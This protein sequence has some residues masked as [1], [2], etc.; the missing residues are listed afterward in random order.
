MCVY[1]LTKSEPEMRESGDGGGGAQQ[2]LHDTNIS[3][4]AMNPYFIMDNSCYSKW[5]WWV[6]MHV[7]LAQ[8]S[9]DMHVHQQYE[10]RCLHE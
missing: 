9:L 6:Y 10:Y 4:V 2:T 1:G 7:T 8:H 3:D 5:N